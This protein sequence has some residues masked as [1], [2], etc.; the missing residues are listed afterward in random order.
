MKPVDPAALVGTW[1]AQRDDGSK[2]DLTLNADNTFNWTVHQQGNDQTMNGTFGV[3]RDLLALESPQAG[4]MVAHVAQADAG[5][6]TF[7][8]LGAP[9]ADQGLTFAR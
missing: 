7:K 8:L 3:E 9:Q 1:H 6:F 2:F 4:G 5:H